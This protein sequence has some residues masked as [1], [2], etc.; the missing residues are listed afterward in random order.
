MRAARL[1]ERLACAAALLAALPAAA[2]TPLPEEELAQVSGAGLAFNLVGFSLTGSRYG[3]LTLTY[4]GSAGSTLWL[5][6]LALSRS[7]D[8]SA[9][10]T[11]PYTLQLIGRGNGLPDVIQ[12]SEPANA[13]GLLKWQ[14]ATDFGINAGS[15]SFLGGAL[16]LQDLRSY[17]GTLSLAPPSTPGVD[18]ASFGLALRADIGNLLLRPRGRDDTTNA[19]APTVG[20]QLRVQGIHLRAYN[21]TAAL[22]TAPWAIADVAQQPGIVN[23]VTVGGMS[24]LHAGIGW[25][26]TAAGAPVGTLVID[27]IAFK[28]DAPGFID[29]ST[30]AASNSF[31]L[32]SSRIGSMQLQFLDIRLRPGP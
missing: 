12:L 14:F 2:L 22:P 11:D 20:E 15:T 21:A 4:T 13:N 5:G 31:S 16:V 19:D 26:T 28:T 10:F 23:A 27:N 6:N 24:S 29:P 25:P 7:D 9:T 17:G 30:G 8:P 3:T 18:G 32:G 1:R